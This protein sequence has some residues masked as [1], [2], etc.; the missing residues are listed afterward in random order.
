MDA[1]SKK[2]KK[3]K[4]DSLFDISL[5]PILAQFPVPAV[6][7]GDGGGKIQRFG[8]RGGERDGRF[9]ECFFLDRNMAT[10]GAELNMGGKG[11]GGRGLEW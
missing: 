7:L 3:K 5:P 4:M 1:P 9:L 2:K 8:V 10:Y 11:R 6:R